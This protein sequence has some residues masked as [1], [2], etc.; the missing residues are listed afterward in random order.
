VKDPLYTPDSFPPG[1]TSVQYLLDKRLGG[2]I[3]IH[4]R[5]DKCFIPATIQILDCPAHDPVTVL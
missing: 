4:S 5:R 1:K 2:T 3:W